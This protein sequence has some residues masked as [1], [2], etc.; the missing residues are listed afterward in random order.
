MFTCSSLMTIDMEFVIN[1]GKAFYLED[2]RIR[3]Y[4]SC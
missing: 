4:M 2:G 3:T 1:D